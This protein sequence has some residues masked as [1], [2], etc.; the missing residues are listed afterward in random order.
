MTP[1]ADH[2][3]KD[4]WSC[5]RSEAILLGKVEVLLDHFQIALVQQ[6]FLISEDP[7]TRMTRTEYT[8]ACGIWK[9][10]FHGVVYLHSTVSQACCLCH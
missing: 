3:V 10:A 1:L 8:L 6:Q 9:E 7:Q 4:N 2:E 5:F